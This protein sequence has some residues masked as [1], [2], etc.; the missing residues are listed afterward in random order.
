[1]AKAKL[2]EKKLLIFHLRGGPQGPHSVRSDQPND[3]FGAAQALWAMTRMGT[4]GQRFN[5]H[6]PDGSPRRYKVIERTDESGVITV[7]CEHVKGGN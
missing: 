6:E 2:P 1:M 4:V 3:T 5:W 7:T